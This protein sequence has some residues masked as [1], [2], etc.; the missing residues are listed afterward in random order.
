MGKRKTV[1]KFFTIPQYQ[2][3]EKFLSEMHENGW[4][5]THVSFPGLYRFE[6][7]EPKQVSYRLDYNQEGIRNKREYIQMFS[8][9]GWEYIE[10]FVGYSYFRKEGQP[11][12]E[13][14]E[15]FCDDASR[16][17][18]MYRVFRGRI[19]P[20]IIIFAMVIIP[21]LYMTTTG[22]GSRSSVQDVLS[23][24]FLGLALLYL[25]LFSVSAFQFYQYEKLVK[26]DSTGFRLKYI[27]ILTLIMVLLIGTCAFFWLSN[28]SVY[29]VKERDYGY[30][31]EAEQLNS[32][33]VKECS[34]KKGD[35]ISFDFNFNLETG[36]IH[37][38]V[39]QKGKEPVFYGDF[40]AFY[41]N[42]APHVI[43][44]QEDGNYIIDIE[45]R[46]VKGEI[47]VIISK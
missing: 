17:D 28:R 29:E 36:Y 44:I 47:E 30:L 1:F 31:I 20:L 39:L 34:L 26:G 14:A 19:I 27:G 13:S 10:D 33:V 42:G 12:E 11:G 15:I 5:F 25:I 40:Y 8:D 6:Q 21:Q 38:N 45:G 9:C 23:F 7:C 24:T 4:S 22:Y 18:M 41:G 46:N 2:Q 35:T 43:T 3:E 37:L 16:L 32:H